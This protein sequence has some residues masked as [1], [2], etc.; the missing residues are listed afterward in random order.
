MCQRVSSSQ[1]EQPASDFRNRAH[2]QHQKMRARCGNQT[3]IA[4]WSVRP[5]ACVCALS[6]NLKVLNS[7]LIT[8]HNKRSSI[9]AVVRRGATTTTT[10]AAVNCIK[11]SLD[12]VQL[13]ELP[14]KVYEAKKAGRMF[15]IAYEHHHHHHHRVG[16]VPAQ[17][18]DVKQTTEPVR[19]DVHTRLSSMSDCANDFP[20][21]IQR[22]HSA[23]RH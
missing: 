4:Q 19:I 9:C 2:A 20:T 11:R 10:A 3:P 6:A 7:L 1:R 17:K 15:D 22:V 16:C 18:S 12:R 5:S 14:G 23:V 8:V 13:N 21:H